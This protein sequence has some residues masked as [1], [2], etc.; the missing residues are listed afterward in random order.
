LLLSS[1]GLLFYFS[2]FFSF[3]CVHALC[4]LA[5]LEAR[6]NSYLLVLI[7]FFY[8]EILSKCCN[9]K[10]VGLFHLCREHCRILL[11]I[12]PRKNIFIII[13]FCLW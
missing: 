3:G 12:Y 6:C 9:R 1:T 11:K 7:Y 4:V 2:F 10:R 5:L 8:C 13:L